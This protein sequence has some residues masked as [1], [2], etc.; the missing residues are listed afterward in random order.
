MCNRVETGDI[1][2]PEKFLMEPKQSLD[3]NFIG[4]FSWKYVCT[5]KVELRSDWERELT[6]QLYFFILAFKNSSISYDGKV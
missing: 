4:T 2:R 6:G 1:F 3:D 5:E